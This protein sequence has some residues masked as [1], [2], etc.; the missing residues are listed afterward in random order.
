MTKLEV[1]DAVTWSLLVLELVLELD[2]CLASILVDNFFTLF[3][4]S[5]FQR[6]PHLKYH[7]LHRHNEPEPDEE[8]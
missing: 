4:G 1:G 6:L 5:G 3:E 8:E 7:Y 2:Q